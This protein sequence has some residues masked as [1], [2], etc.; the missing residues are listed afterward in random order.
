VKH[1]FNFQKKT[2]ARTNLSP[3]LI[4]SEKSH[5]TQN[6]VI[7]FKG[8]EILTEEKDFEKGYKIINI[9]K[10]TENEL[11]EA[12]SIVKLCLIHQYENVQA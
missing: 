10:A 11:Q 4:R 8:F 3:I 6:F 2:C 12:Q 5:L 9:T 7:A 1:R